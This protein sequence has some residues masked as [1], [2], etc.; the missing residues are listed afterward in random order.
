MFASSTRQCLRWQI[1]TR[2]LFRGNCLGETAFVHARGPFR[3]LGETVAASS[4][5][6]P[7]ASYKSGRDHCNGGEHPA[8]RERSPTRK[9]PSLAQTGLSRRSL[10]G[11]FLAGRRSAERASEGPT[12]RV[13]IIMCCSPN[14]RSAYPFN[15]VLGPRLHAGRRRATAYVRGSS[16]ATAARSRPRQWRRAC[17]CGRP[18]GSVGHARGVKSSARLSMRCRASAVASERSASVRRWRS[19]QARS[20]LYR[21]SFQPHPSRARRAIA[22]DMLVLCGPSPIP[23]GARTVRL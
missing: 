13:R 2:S 14:S 22:P 18:S 9:W 3:T 7:A 20:T 21:Q 15:L 19:R 6:C 8:A 5:P 1:P 11:S 4:N 17:A 10:P 16:A 23:A 12:E